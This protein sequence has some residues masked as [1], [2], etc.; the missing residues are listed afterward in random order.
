MRTLTIVRHAKSSWD[1]PEIHDFD[2]PLNARGQRDAPTMG[3]HLKTLSFMPDHIVCSPA[4]RALTTATVLCE[5]IGF[6][7]A[8]IERDDRV[9]EASLAQLQ[10]LIEQ[11]DPQH[12]H[13]L[14]CGHNPGLESLCHLVAPGSITSL[15]T[16]NVVQYTLAI[17]DWP[18]FDYDCGT[19]QY[20]LRPKDISA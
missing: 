18:A 19:L 16:C 14:V 20:H 7:S 9:Y 2:R 6:D 8:G 5:Q 13:V 1:N 15:T 4:R 3:K 11:Q 12:H 10:T 17:K